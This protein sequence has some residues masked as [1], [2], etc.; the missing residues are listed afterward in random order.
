M[1]EEGAATSA[2]GRPAESNDRGRSLL[3]VGL[4]DGGS[5]SRSPSRSGSYSQTSAGEV[6]RL[7][8]EAESRS[9][10][11]LSDLRFKIRS[12]EKERNEA[13]EEWAVKLQ[14]RVHELEKLRRV[15]AEKEGEYAESL[16]KR[17]EKDARTAEGNEAR[18]VLEKEIKGLKAK[19]EEMKEDVEVAADGEVRPDSSMLDFCCAGEAVRDVADSRLALSQRRA[20]HPSFTALNDSGSAGRIA[21]AIRQPAIGEQDP[22]RRTPQGSTLGAAHGASTQPG[23][24]VLV[25]QPRCAEQRDQRRKRQRQWRKE[26]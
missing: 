13:E 10:A 20:F 19:I 18:K 23:S 3:G 9:E 12:L 5:L 21:R 11:K 8:A 2:S 24:R 14:E 7:L 16:R 26:W 4:P 1:L 6:Q 15:I 17:D 25:R 22:P